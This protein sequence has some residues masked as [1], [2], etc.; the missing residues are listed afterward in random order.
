MSQYCRPDRV[1]VGLPVT[2]VGD[3]LFSCPDAIAAIPRI[4]KPEMRLLFIKLLLLRTRPHNG[5]W[6]GGKIQVPD[7]M[8]RPA[9][10]G[11]LIASYT[12]CRFPTHM[13]RCPQVPLPNKY[14]HLV[15]V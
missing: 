5:S 13:I 9:P 4:I 15:N 2:F 14:A 11:L 7:G 6:R 1:V 3:A 12:N 8:G 10:C